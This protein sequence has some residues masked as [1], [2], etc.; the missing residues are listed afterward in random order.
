M[1]RMLCVILL[2]SVGVIHADQKERLLPVT[3]PE[4]AWEN[5]HDV[6]DHAED[7]LL[8]EVNVAR[9]KHG[10]GSLTSEEFYSKPID[11]RCGP[12][13]CLLGTAFYGYFVGMLC[14]VRYLMWRMLA[15]SP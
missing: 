12:R 15:E 3:T 8:T 13:E 6:V 2:L 11:R 7:D 14:G 4:G 1:K 10:H 9:V 5:D